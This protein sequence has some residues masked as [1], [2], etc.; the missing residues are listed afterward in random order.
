MSATSKQQKMNSYAF[1]HSQL[2]G[3]VI[4]R[5]RSGYTS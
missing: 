4:L 3:I 2:K 1:R 5:I